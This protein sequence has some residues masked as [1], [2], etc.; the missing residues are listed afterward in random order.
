M[1]LAKGFSE[2]LTQVPLSLPPPASLPPDCKRGIESLYY[3]CK[4]AVK[5]KM[6]LQ[7]QWESVI[8]RLGSKTGYFQRLY[9]DLVLRIR[10]SKLCSSELVRQPHLVGDRLQA[11]LSQVLVSECKQTP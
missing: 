3:D 10:K 4:A 2:S 11:H 9:P 8:G 6:S 1:S 7:S 5:R